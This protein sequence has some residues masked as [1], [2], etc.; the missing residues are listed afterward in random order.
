MNFLRQYSL[1]FALVLAFFI[2]RKSSCGCNNF[3]LFSETARGTGAML[4]QSRPATG[5]VNVSSSC[6]GDVEVTQDSTFSVEIEAQKEILDIIETVVEG[7]T[8]K[9]R[10]KKGYSIDGEV[11]V[12]VHAPQ[13]EDLSLAG[14]GN[15]VAKTALNCPKLKVELAGSGRIELQNLQSSDFSIGVAGSGDV[16]CSGGA[17]TTADVSVA[18]SGDIDLEKLAVKK[19]KISIS[20]SGN[21]TCNVEET[22]DANV[23]GSGDI[24]YKGKPMTNTH[25]SGSGTVSGF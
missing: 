14:S 22:L 20:G 18:G 12:R 25:V 9:V 1:F 8:L 10:V 2:V 16:V 4:K 23:S 6:S 15:L 13:F 21:A 24:K 19:M 5:F 3:S 11:H 7:N 17:V